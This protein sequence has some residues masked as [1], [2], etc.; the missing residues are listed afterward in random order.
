MSLSCSVLRVA[1]L[2]VCM[3]NL[4][5][6]NTPHICVVHLAAD[7]FAQPG[8]PDPDIPCQPMYLQHSMLLQKE[9]GATAAAEQLGAE[10]AQ[11]IAKAAAKKA[12]K[13]K[14]KARKQQARSDGTSASASSPL[15]SMLTQLDLEPSTTLHQ[16]SVSS[17]SASQS[18]AAA[19]LHTEQSAAP[20]AALHQAVN[21]LLVEEQGD[22]STP[23]ADTAGHSVQLHAPHDEDE[24]S[25]PAAAAQESSSGKGQGAVD[26]PQGADATFLDQPFCC[27]LTKVAFVENVSRMFSSFSAT[28]HAASTVQM[29]GRLWLCTSLYIR[30]IRTCRFGKRIWECKRIYDMHKLL[31]KCLWQQTQSAVTLS[32]QSVQKLFQSSVGRHTSPFARNTVLL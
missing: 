1:L 16:S 11:E 17:P 18:P 6:T 32:C 14:A 7:K 12:K 27:P 24:V 10:E 28:C 26:A 20:A 2:P 21:E 30:D 29:L 31:Q 5:P 9:D 19:I 4:M 15:P 8:G 23:G 3:H 25:R 22:Q 13:Q